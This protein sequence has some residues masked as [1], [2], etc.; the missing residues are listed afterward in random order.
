[1]PIALYDKAHNRRL[2]EITVQQRDQLVDA[3][4]EESSKDRDYYI[5]ANVLDFLAG[6]VDAELLDQLRPLVGAAPAA[7]SDVEMDAELDDLPEVLETDGEL[8]GLDIEW[9]EE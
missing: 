7:P 6:K 4:E 2:F 8:P 5:D 3:L 9:R 1:M